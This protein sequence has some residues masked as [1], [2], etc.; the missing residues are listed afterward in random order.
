[1]LLRIFGYIFGIGAFM[2]LGLAVAAGV[3][4]QT[5]NAGLPDYDRLA[6][7]EPPV[8]TRIHAAD[9]ELMAEHAKERRLYLPIQAV[10]DLIKAAFLSA[11]DKNFYEHDGLDMS[12]IFRA[13]LTNLRNS[14]SGKRPIGASTI[15]QQ[16]AKNFLLTNEVSYERKIKEALLALRIEQAYSVPALD[17]AV[18]VAERI[19]VLRRL[20]QRREIGRLPDRQLVDRLVEVVERRRRHSIRAEA[21][22]DLVQVKLE[23]LVLR[24]GLLDAQ[25]EQRLLDLPLVGDLVRQQKILRDLLRDGRSADGPLAGSAIPEIG[26]E[27]AEDARHVEPVVLIEILVL[28][29]KERRLEKVGH[30]LDGQVKPALLGVLRHQLAVGGMDAGHHRRL[31]IRQ[32]VVVR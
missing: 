32:P 9:G 4:L 7:Y 21:E 31:V 22:I 19:V 5:F 26:H 10:P 18:L 11:E 25:R 2:L 14:G 30:C 8:M 17:G 20:R 29:G 6:N 24:I 3:L 28:G 15:T 16:V 12:G 13:L 1:M 23:N 27:R